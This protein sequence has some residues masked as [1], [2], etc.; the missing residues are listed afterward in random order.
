MRTSC[1]W[2]QTRILFVEPTY[3]ALSGER[4]A[5]VFNVLL[6]RSAQGSLSLLRLGEQ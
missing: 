6:A 1:A 4:S 2:S 5:P 3:L